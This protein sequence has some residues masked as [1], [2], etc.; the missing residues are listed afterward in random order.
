MS[1]DSK[2]SMGMTAK[3]FMNHSQ[4]RDLYQRPVKQTLNQTIYMPNK[5]NEMRSRMNKTEL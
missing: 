1:F 2:E 3:V 4:Y 5:Q